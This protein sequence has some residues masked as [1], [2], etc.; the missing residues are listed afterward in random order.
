MASITGNNIARIFVV[1]L[2]ALAMPFSYGQEESWPDYGGGPDSSHFVGSRQITKD[3]V[4]QLEVA[5]VYPYGETGFN[6]I[7]VDNYMYV[8]G[9][10]SSLIALEA[11]TGKA[12]WIHEGLRGISSRGINYWESKDRKDRRL[13]FSVNSFLQELD[14][15]TGMTI[16]S[17]GKDGVVNLRDGLERDPSK[18]GRVQSLSPGKIFENLV[19]LGSAPGEAYVS[20]P[21]DLRAYD[22]RTGKL[23][24]QFH[25]VPH[26]G[27]PHY[28]AFPKD[29]WKYVGGNNTWG[30]LTI[31]ARNGIAFF[32]LGAPTYDF[33]GADRTGSNLYGD[34]LLALDARTG[35]YLW[36]FQDIHHDLWD[37]DMTAAPQLT[38][39]RHDGKLVEVVAEAGKTG[40]L[41]V[42][43]RK[44]GRPI[45]P[46]VER[47]VPQSDVP[48]EHSWPTQ[49]F[50]TAPPPFARQKFTTADINP[51]LPDDQRSAIRDQLLS[52]R[53]DGL[54][55]PPT[56]RGTVQMPGNQG[57][58]NWGTTAANPNNGTV[59]V[60]GIDAPAVIKLEKSEPG[61]P[62]AD[63][64]FG[65]RP[66]ST[67]GS[68][69][70]MK[71]I[72]AGRAIYADSCQVCHGADLKGGVGPSIADVTLKMGADAIRATIQGGK[73]VMPSFS[74][75]PS[76][77]VDNLMAFL[78]NHD[79]PA[80]GSLPDAPPPA[81]P[82]VA[83]GPAPASLVN[84]A[85][86][87][88]I[89]ELFGVGGNG[90]NRPYPEGVHVP[91]IR[92]NSGW[93]VS[94]DAIKPPWATITA[95]DLNKGTIKWQVPAGDDP[96]L[97]AQGIHNTGSRQLRTGI[98]PT[99]TG[100]VFNV[101]GDKK[102][103][104]YDED[105]GEVLWVK[106]IGGNSRGVPAMYE[107]NGREYLVISTSAR[108]GFGLSGSPEAP[109]HPANAGN[110][111]KSGDRTNA[112]TK[113]NSGDT[114]NAVGQT[115]Q[116]NAAAGGL[117][118]GY[119]AFAL[120]VKEKAGK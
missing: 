6:P 108:S 4:N 104:A 23:V 111:G 99:A 65:S 105:T 82:V 59:Y 95:Y 19:I 7:I 79:M 88:G 3:N 85:A 73:G 62:F 67:N 16:M 32:P 39:I 41:Y 115:A 27:E 113:V 64:F 35:R 55:T 13:I 89:A 53:N 51:Y 48:G 36:H 66:S 81:G 103:R 20:P 34:C 17:F 11:T 15:L 92:Y 78:A 90:G 45:W 8:L 97:A 10:N 101:G 86:E 63:A 38:T 47:P 120:P 46:I 49:P 25:T 80:F 117:P 100:L 60:L 5:W 96:V 61:A 1:A 83:S 94:Y 29:A 18:I 57:G 71:Q 77:D 110:G 102:L 43:D 21:G 54:F 106:E 119:I 14:A 24:W 22:V 93:G 70:G 9:R 50:P 116:A 30:D 107:V 72:I 98:I 76:S 2:C 58:A 28:D 44:T 40:F 56:L 91:P 31:D 109:P 112:A 114:S 87:Q 12:I 52:W 68:L 26:P 42:L 33:Y 84:T 118:T 75:L 74:S 69:R 37:Y